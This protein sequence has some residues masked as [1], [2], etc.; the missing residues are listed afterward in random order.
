[1]SRPVVIAAFTDHDQELRTLRY[2]AEN[3]ED[4]LREAAKKNLCQYRI[5]R[6]ATLEKIKKV[7]QDPEIRD[8][9][10]IF[11]Y[12]GHASVNALL[13]ESEHGTK[14]AAYAYGLVP[15]LTSIKSIQ[16]IFLNGCLSMQMAE[17]LNRSGV[18]AVAGTVT[19]IRDDL[20]T[21]LSSSFYQGL[22]KGLPLF[23]A[24][25]QATSVVR[26]KKGEDFSRYY[27]LEN[28][29]GD[30][31]LNT[32]Y[33]R[34]P[35]EL[36]FR[37]GSEAVKS[38]SL[39]I[40]ARNPLF[41]LPDI[42]SNYDL[43]N[44][45]YRY[46]LPYKHNDVR[47]FFGRGHDI[48]NVYHRLI[49]KDSSPLILLSGQS[50]VGKSSMLT[51]GLIPRLEYVAETRYAKRSL[52]KG[53]LWNL[54]QLLGIWENHGRIDVDKLDK[55][56]ATTFEEA[57]HRIEQEKDKPL[58]ILLDQVETFFTH[59][60]ESELNDLSLLIR[61]IKDIFDNP[62]KRPK[63]KLLLSYRKEYHTEISKLIIHHEIAKEEVFLQRLNQQ[64][65][66]EVINGLQSTN[67]H[68]NKYYLKIDPAL[69][70]IISLDLTRDEASP[71]APVLQIILT[72]M[73]Y[74]V[75]K[76][77]GKNFSL[78]LY[79]DIQKQG[80]HLHD[81][82]DQQ[83]K[84]LR[85]WEEHIQIP[86]ERSGLALDLL[87][88]HTTTFGTVTP[89]SREELHDQY[90]LP[91][92]L[93]D[94]LI[95]K[96]ESLYLL[97]SNKHQQT[98]LT[99]DMLASTIRIK[100]KDSNLPGQRARR[101][102]EAKMQEYRL[103]KASTF[104][105]ETD[106]ELI[107]KGAN[108]MCQWGEEERALIKKSKTKNALAKASKRRYALLGKLAVVA[109]LISAIVA[110]FFWQKN[111]KAAQ[112]NA[113]VSQ[114][115][116]KEKYDPTLAL[117]SIRK[118]V[119]MESTHRLAVQT[120]HD[121][122]SNNEFYQKTIPHDAAVVAVDISPDDKLVVTAA[123]K[124]IFIWSSEGQLQTSL[125]FSEEVTKVVF[126]PKGDQL[127]V[128]TKDN[129]AILCGLNQERIRRFNHNDWVTAIDFSQD[130]QKVL[131]GD[132]S[133]QIRL[134]SIS[135]G[136][137]LQIEGHS[138]PVLSLGFSPTGDTLISGSWD[139]TARIWKV[140]GTPIGPVLDHSN[141]VLSVAFSEDGQK[142][143]TAD[144]NSMV[145]IWDLNGNIQTR[146]V[147]HNRRVN[148]ALWLSLANSILSASDDYKIK[149]WNTKGK[150]LREYKGHLDFVYDVALSSNERW[151]AS[152]SADSTLRIWKI[153]SKNALFLGPFDQNISDVTFSNCGQFMFTS[154]RKASQS[155]LDDF[156]FDYYESM[157]PCKA[158]MW[159]KEGQLIRSFEG[160]QG[161]INSTSVAQDDQMILTAGEDRQAIL[162]DSS[163]NIIRRF[164]HNGEVNN[165][166]FSPSGNEIITSGSDSIAIRW[167]LDGKRKTVY[168]GHTNLVSTAIFSPDAQHIL[169]ACYDDTI[170]MFNLKGE[171]IRQL[172]GHN[173]RISSIAY[174]PDGKKILSAAWDNEAI[175][176]SEEGEI[177]HRFKINIKNQT[178]GQAINTVAFSRDGKYIAL[179]AEGG[180]VKIY[181]L[182]GQEIQ[183][184]YLKNQLNVQGIDF[185]PDSQ[186]ILIGSKQEVGLW[187]T[188]FN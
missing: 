42:S 47:V 75:E 94:Q 12:A 38:W 182:D 136:T 77:Q 188:L 126:S 187:K 99:H 8:K 19:K 132:R 14:K 84:K 179:G 170:R 112:I 114:A 53:L 115:L 175:L 137:Y 37:E 68:R 59:R 95:R 141:R 155:S 4:A 96:L 165:A 15:L 169:T 79:R 157:I 131:V 113:L 1:M 150:E 138:S 85:Q 88:Y 34:L 41:G 67:A 35:W 121:I 122:Y 181:S 28:T 117:N 73:W 64:G 116:A 118:A 74:A 186:S 90:S 3:I 7:F 146:I 16:F 109:I 81:F 10:A 161:S 127:L 100:V 162:W 29:R 25:K 178:G 78:L 32:T 120:R 148:R 51:A 166:D 30:V 139:H 24:W 168:K 82:Y 23:E 48:Q 108:G 149:L 91:K 180:V 133:G 56:F 46:L 171:L 142:I 33:E 5:I 97:Y 177:L 172:I 31:A 66:E 65:I 27:K 119:S 144:R 125:S 18:P 2:E 55:E 17:S 105:D 60:Q 57:W 26:A 151:F 184:I 147:G 61:C 152:A 40:A 44:H 173:S 21:Q 50:G 13:L 160:H 176:W 83:M 6:N 106:L 111:K 158:I 49:G 36:S 70:R 167:S 9:I 185:S 174:S 52:E 102:L 69:P 140:D 110:T 130:G 143:L 159:N 39:P 134:W 164:Q 104:I 20:A 86:V 153:D 80:F 103:H 154:S 163:G 145:F 72:K 93:L 124:N 128:G 98:S 87:Y 45:P 11:H 22:S 123:G 76:N 89:R 71:I 58:L 129:A 63:G 62:Q 43:P 92:K 101:L 107:E 183:S 54:G 135:D 156:D